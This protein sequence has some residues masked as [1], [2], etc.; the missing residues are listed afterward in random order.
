MWGGPGEGQ[1]ASL[2][3]H[4]LLGYNRGTN[5][6]RTMAIHVTR[7]GVALTVGIILVIGLIIGGLFWAKNQ[8]EQARRDDAINIAEENL[9]EQSGEDV[10]LN[11]GDEA[12]NEENNGAPTESTTNNG[13]A[14]SPASVPTAG[15]TELP[16]TGPSDAI[17]VLGLLLLAFSATSYVIS[18][19][20]LRSL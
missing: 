18:V 14:N 4:S 20:T 5:G 2:G 11:D 16:Q 9:E 8:G 13:A 3:T 17:A 1:N 19:R 7:A 12:T 10:A 15:T 6:R